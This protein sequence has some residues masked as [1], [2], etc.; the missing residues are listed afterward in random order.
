MKTFF[1]VIVISVTSL[2]ASAASKPKID[3][4]NVVLNDS[5]GKPV[6]SARLTQTKSGVR[7]ALEVSGLTPGGEQAIHFHAKGKCEGPGFESAGPHFAPEP[8][9]HGLKNPKGH[10]AG[11]MENIKVGSDGK[12]KAKFTNRF[13]TLGEGVNS[14]LQEGGTSLV[15]HAKADDHISQPAGDAGGRIVCGVISQNK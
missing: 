7:I 13:V 5:A 9:E 3:P 1:A 6:G 10:H 12:A 11:D 2:A 4:I 8:K 15:I 14:L